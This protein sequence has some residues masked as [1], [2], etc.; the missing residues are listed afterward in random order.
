MRSNPS[1]F[2]RILVSAS[3]SVELPTLSALFP[4]M[5]N[6]FADF[7]NQF[8][9]FNRREIDA[10]CPHFGLLRSALKPNYADTGKFPVF[11]LQNRETSYR[12]A[13]ALDCGHHH[14]FLR[15]D[16]CGAIR[17]WRRGCAAEK[18]PLLSLWLQRLSGRPAAGPCPLEIVP[19]KPAGH[20]YR[21]ADGVK[22][23]NAPRFHGS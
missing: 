2:S 22:T 18:A 9:V 12:D 14:S 3:D 13:F 16:V 21:L 20:V 5:A 10:K 17:R 7:S 6:I 19:A 4:E 15:R 8:P 23:G 11:S 1:D